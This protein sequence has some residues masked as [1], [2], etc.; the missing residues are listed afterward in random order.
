[1]R[2]QINSLIFLESLWV[3]QFLSLWKKNSKINETSWIVRS[4]RVVELGFTNVIWFFFRKLYFFKF[5]KILKLFK[6]FQNYGRILFIPWTIIFSSLLFCKINILG[7][8]IWLVL[9]D[10]FCIATIKILNNSISKFRN[11]EY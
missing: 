8:L 7:I 1:M 3:F 9:S 11:D 10:F 5:G 2:Y 6:R 4:F